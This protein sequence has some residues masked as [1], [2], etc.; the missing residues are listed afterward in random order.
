M[1][2]LYLPI[3]VNPEPWAIGPVGYARRGG[4]MSAYVGQNKQLDAYK[5]AVAESAKPLLPADHILWNCD[6][7]LEFYFWR[8]RADYKTPQA[9]TARKHEA[10][11]T[12]MVKA[13]EDALQG[14]VYKNDRD[15]KSIIAHLVEQGPD[16]Q[17]RILVC[18]RRE[19]SASL[20]TSLPI[21][22]LARL[23]SFRTVAPATPQEARYQEAPD[24][25]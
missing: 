19:Y 17:G 1:D 20:L 23:E 21:D 22:V 16:V 3:D 8:Q 18:V 11:L 7:Q 14:V 5:Q 25:F 4:K 12:N 9:R 13:T 2:T 10:D 15:T 24:T 6:M